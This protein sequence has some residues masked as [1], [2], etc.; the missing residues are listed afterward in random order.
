MVV[1]QPDQ[2]DLDGRLNKR[3]R[4][5]H[6][7]LQRDGLHV[8][9]G[10][11]DGW[12]QCNQLSEHWPARL[13]ELLV[14]RARLQSGGTSAYSNTASATTAWGRHSL[15]TVVASSSQIN[16]TWTDTSTSE[17]DSAS[18]V[19]AARGVRHC[20]DRDGWRQCDQ[21][22]EH[23]A[24]RLDELLVPRARLQQ[25][26]EFRLL[27][28]EPLQ[29]FGRDARDDVPLPGVMPTTASGI[30]DTRIIVSATSR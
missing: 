5:P 22:S 20:R 26:R 6:R 12:R 25:R 3:E 1:E 11:R 28:H 9:C 18:S 10:D 15:R 7:A 21:L 19:A 16:L 2:S 4:V 14:P 8:V 27:E 30:P 24:G 29:R 23:R 13:D 17:T